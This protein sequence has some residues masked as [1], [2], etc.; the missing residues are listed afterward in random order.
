MKQYRQGKKTERPF[1]ARVITLSEID[2]PQNTMNNN[3]PKTLYN[4]ISSFNDPDNLKVRAFELVV[5]I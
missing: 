5:F 2:R 1:G 4:S 3:A